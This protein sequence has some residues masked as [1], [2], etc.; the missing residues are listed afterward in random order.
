MVLCGFVVLYRYAYPYI[1]SGPE[2]TRKTREQVHE[3]QRQRDALK[4]ELVGLEGRLARYRNGQEEG[5]VRAGEVGED[6]VHVI[7]RASRSASVRVM[8]LMAAGGGRNSGQ[9]Y[10][11][12]VSGGYGGI[13]AFVRSLVEYPSSIVVSEISIQAAGW[14]YPSQPLEAKLLLE[15][16]STAR[17]NG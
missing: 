3:L 1:V 2:S 17:K 8:G 9:G 4:V 5:V 14:M 16:H 10:Q 11:L 7:D 6:L 13:S 12:T 15:T